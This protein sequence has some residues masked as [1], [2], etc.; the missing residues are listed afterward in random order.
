MVP[1]LL[2][3]AKSRAWS[4]ATLERGASYVEHQQEEGRTMPKGQDL[5]EA[6]LQHQSYM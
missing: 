5:L 2:P 4:C 3:G 1:A 6:I